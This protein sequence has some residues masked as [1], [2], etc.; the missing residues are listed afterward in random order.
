MVCCTVNQLETERQ[1][2]LS[3][4]SPA[5]VQ[6]AAWQEPGLL[7][8]VST[9]QQPS[10]L[11]RVMD[12]AAK[13]TENARTQQEVVRNAAR[14]WFWEANSPDTGARIICRSSPGCPDVFG[15]LRTVGS[16]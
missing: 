4:V 8:P 15:T 7:G 6:P 2:L 5:D 16:T 13:L 9:G 3:S 14:L 10:Y 11:S 12:R 1:A